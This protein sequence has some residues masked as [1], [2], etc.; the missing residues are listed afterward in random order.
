MFKQNNHKFSNQINHFLFNN[1]L[2]ILH[3]LGNEIL[4]AREGY[5]TWLSN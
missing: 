4:E 1:F 3:L 2:A 5:C